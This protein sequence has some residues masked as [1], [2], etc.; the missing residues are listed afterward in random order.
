MQSEGEL[1]GSRQ[2]IALIKA[3]P[4]GKAPLS[5]P[6]A[7]PAAAARRYCAA[8]PI[9]PTAIRFQDQGGICT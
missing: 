5:D 4:G 1:H 2:I 3:R 6:H 9:K 7:V 8:S